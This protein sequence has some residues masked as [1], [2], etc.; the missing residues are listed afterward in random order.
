MPQ[1]GVA[2]AR[3]NGHFIKETQRGLGLNLVLLLFF[4]LI[5]IDLLAFCSVFLRGREAEEGGSEIGDIS[6]D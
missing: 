4:V 1:H 6:L 2:I 5:F 3:G